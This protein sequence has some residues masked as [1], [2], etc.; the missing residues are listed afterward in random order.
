MK[1]FGIG[2]KLFGVL[3]AYG[4]FNGSSFEYDLLT[5]LF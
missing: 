1:F 5:G 4:H 3:F 2:I